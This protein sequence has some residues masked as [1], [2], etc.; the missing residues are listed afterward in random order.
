MAVKK[1]YFFA[2][3]GLITLATLAILMNK[4]I[5]PLKGII[6]A[7]FGNRINPVTGQPEFHN[8]VDVSAGY[9]TTV[10][11]PANG[12]VLSVYYNDVGGNQVVIQHSG[13]I[14]GYA[15]L[16]RMT[17]IQ[18]QNV[19][20]GQKVAEVGTSGQTTGAHLH[21]TVQ[22]NSAFIDPLELFTFNS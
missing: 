21:F 2:G 16:S 22:R 9:G 1:K 7:R 20:Q 14:T 11:S 18:G 10:R 8:G 13:I 19:I 3:I 5:N 4:Y 15:H 17:V 12:K 6:T